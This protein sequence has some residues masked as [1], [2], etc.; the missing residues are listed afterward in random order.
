MQRTLLI[1]RD[2]RELKI[3]FDSP[4]V[5]AEIRIDETGRSDIIVDTTLELDE[6]SGGALDIATALEQEDGRSGL[7]T[8]LRACATGSARC[9]HLFPQGNA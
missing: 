2:G 7:I 6:C 1:Y 9:H 5:I 8:L 4:A 3:C